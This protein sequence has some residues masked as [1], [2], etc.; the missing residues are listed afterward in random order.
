MCASVIVCKVSSKAKL[1]L[2]RNADA[3]EHTLTLA[4]IVARYCIIVMN[5]HTHMGSDIYS[6]LR[7]FSKAK[8]L[9]VAL[10]YNLLQTLRTIHPLAILI[11]TASPMAAGATTCA[12]V[13]S[14]AAVTQCA[15]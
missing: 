14:M 10:C 13:S 12:T 1:K 7:V 8:P 15:V 11:H 2:N 9:R 5:S 4:I 3:L 6:L